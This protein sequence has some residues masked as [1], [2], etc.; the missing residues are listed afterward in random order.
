[1]TV[2]IYGDGLFQK[3]GK[4]KSV[5]LV[6]SPVASETFF[7]MSHRYDTEKLVQVRYWK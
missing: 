3:S 6:R 4:I 1:M 7:L 2:L 5:I